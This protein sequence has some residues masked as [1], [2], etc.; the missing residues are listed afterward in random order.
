[1]DA[2]ISSRRY[3]LDWMRV[4]AILTIF[5]YHSTRFFNS[6]DWHVKNPL[7]YPLVDVWNMFASD[8]MMPLIFAI[9]GASLFYALGKGGVAAAA[10]KFIK[11]KVLRLLVP[12]MVGMFTAGLIQVYLERVS[13]YQF[14]GTLFQFL[15]HYFEGIYG[16][17]PN[18]NFALVGNH[19]WYL[20]V[21]FILSLLCLPLL[22]L[23]RS[24][25]GSW[26]LGKLTDFL[27]IPG[28]F[29]LLGVV[30]TFLNKLDPDSFWGF[31]KFN[32][33]LAVYLAFLLFGYMLMASTKLQHSIQRLRWVSLLVTVFLTVLILRGE[34]HDDWM[35]WFFTLTAF[36]FGMKHLNFN[37]SFLAYASE[38]VLP[39]Y[40]LHQTVLLC[41][42]FFVV[43]WNLPGLLKWAI[44]L[45]VSF[46]I[47]MALYE[48]VV[49]RFN[50]LRVLFGMKPLSRA[51]VMQPK[52]V[53]AD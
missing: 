51:S 39:F 31:D 21:L 24:R 17:T 23:L 13:H 40:I 47:I 7:T 2:K 35:A 4:F 50:I 44:I 32:F 38:A 53:P 3:D 9:S 12:L 43:Q 27:A 22:F 18:G 1:M 48:F 5:V 46:V 6:D 26:A 52:A 30:I 36:G 34:N 14:T 15:P 45:P 33:N 37:K 16:I 8:W 41:V 10:G 42:G 19:L 25:P 29:Y 11:D 28:V 20:A 49:R